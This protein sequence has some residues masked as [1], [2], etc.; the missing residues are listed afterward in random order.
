MRTLQRFDL[1]RKTVSRLGVLCSGKTGPTRHDDILLLGDWC[2]LATLR[3][4]AIYHQLCP[5]TKRVPK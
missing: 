4:V 5:L 2:K 3:L 1:H